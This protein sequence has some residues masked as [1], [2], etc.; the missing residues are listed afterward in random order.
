M[1]TLLISLKHKPHIGNNIFSGKVKSKTSSTAT[2]KL[3][4]N[5]G[6]TGVI[7][8]GNREIHIAK[9]LPSDETT[10]VGFENYDLIYLNPFTTCL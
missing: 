5:K 10:P 3:D 7:S 6:L 8:D 4:K 9:L 1:E 2:I